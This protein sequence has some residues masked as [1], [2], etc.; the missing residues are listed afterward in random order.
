MIKKPT[1][2]VLVCAIVLGG[3]YYYMNWHD[4]KAAKSA[5]SIFKSAFTIQAAD[6]NSITVSRPSQSTQPPIRFDRNGGNWQIAQPT[7]TAADS[8]VVDQSLGNVVSSEVV[9]TEPDTPDR[10]K[11]FGLDPG[12]LSVTMQ[13]KSGAKHTLLIG[14]KIFDGSS[15][16][17]IID[18]AKSVSVLP[19]SAR[20]SFDKSLDDFRDH[21]VLHVTSN[22]VAS[23][24]LKNPSGD[25]ALTKNKDQWAFSTPVETRAD[26]DSI[27]S[28]LMAVQNAKFTT[29]ASEKP[30]D[31]AKYGLSIPSVS[32]TTKDDTGKTLTLVVGK[33]DG[34]NYFA[35]DTSRPTIFDVPGDLYTQLTKKFTDLRDK[36]VLH[37]DGA[38]LTRIEVH[39]DHGTI[40]GDRK[41]SDTWTDES[42]DP[43]R[44]KAAKTDKLLD[45]LADL[46]SDQ[47]VDHPGADLT[48]KLARPAIDVSLTDKNKK[49]TNLK[50]SKPM[51]DVVYAQSSEGSAVYKLKKQDFDKLDFDAAALTQ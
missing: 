23:F 7:E 14:D 41:F 6:V 32:L 9:E 39:N 28:L 44:A 47:I 8:S 15:V 12:Q 50:I 18:G 37:F 22:Q 49:T 19:D 40:L 31:L 36:K 1:L 29:V 13:M 48:S 51:G 21:T 3:V 20:A 17:A 33:K 46:Q 27:N 16:Y 24:T 45:P 42:P 30:D 38:D 10:I 35:R 43:H 34:N 26:Q 25:L 4:T 5:P 2:I 11:A